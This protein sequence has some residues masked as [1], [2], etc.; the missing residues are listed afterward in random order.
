MFEPCDINLPVATVNAAITCRQEI[1]R[2]L[3]IID[4][5]DLYKPEQATPPQS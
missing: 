2:I 4:I 1:G 5:L 3:S